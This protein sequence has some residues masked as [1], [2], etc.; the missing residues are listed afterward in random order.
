MAEQV[1][2][3]TSAGSTRGH[4]TSGRRGNR[5]TPRSGTGSSAASRTGDLLL[6]ANVCAAE[7]VTAATRL[8]SF[9]F[10]RLAAKWPLL[11]LLALLTSAVGNERA[12]A[13]SSSASRSRSGEIT[14]RSFSGAYGLASG[15]RY[16]RPQPSDGESRS[17][18]VTRGR[19]DGRAPAVATSSRHTARGPVSVRQK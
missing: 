8:D 13:R 6:D 17:S 7:S 16:V 18:T 14:A 2:P 5:T 9:T 19:N 11:P 3:S 1:R 10:G 4:A 12:H 15:T